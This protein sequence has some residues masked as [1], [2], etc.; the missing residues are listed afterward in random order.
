MSLIIRHIDAT[1]YELVQE[2]VKVWRGPRPGSTSAALNV[3]DRHPVYAGLDP[4]DESAPLIFESG[5]LYVM[6][7]S[8]KTVASY[9]LDVPGQPSSA[10]RS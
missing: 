8:G 10:A 2:V 6:S 4:Y 1:G 5:D 9:N 7:P 3:V